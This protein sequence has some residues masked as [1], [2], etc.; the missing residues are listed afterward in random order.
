MFAGMSEMKQERL[1]NLRYIL[2]E[3]VIPFD[4][5]VITAYEHAG[6]ILDWRIQDTEDIRHGR[7]YKTDRLWLGPFGGIQCSWYR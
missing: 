6:L 7:T 4:E 1:P 5:E 2:F 3:R